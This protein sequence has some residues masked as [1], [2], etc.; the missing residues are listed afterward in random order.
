MSNGFLHPE[1]SMHD[2]WTHAGMA[3]VSA[4]AATAAKAQQLQIGSILAW[5]AAVVA[6]NGEVWDEWRCRFA[7]GVPID[8]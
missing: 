3:W 4:F 2:H 5:Q 7:G 6:I 1:P 8:G